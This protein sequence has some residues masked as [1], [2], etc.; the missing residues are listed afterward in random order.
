MREITKRRYRAAPRWLALG[1]MTVASFGLILLTGGWYTA[2]RAAYLVPHTVEAV[3]P[4][5]FVPLPV[6]ASVLAPYGAQQV[7]CARAADGRVL[8]YAVDTAVR[9]YKSDIRVR[10]VISADGAMLLSMQ[11]LAQNETEYLGERV[12]TEAFAALFAGRRM[13]LKLA[14]SVGLGSPVDALSGATISSQAVVDAVNNASELVEFLQNTAEI[15]RNGLT[16]KF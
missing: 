2:A 11:V 5:A 10:S 6:E 8:G 7:M 16:T 3:P 4:T 15:P 9:G 12:Q 1:L 13:P 14:Q